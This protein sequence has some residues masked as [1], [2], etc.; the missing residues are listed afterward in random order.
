[1][2]NVFVNDLNSIS[3]QSQLVQFADDAQFLVFGTPANL[4]DIV[5]N[6]E[7]TLNRAIR[8]F[9][10]NG[11]KVNS[12]KTKCIFIGSRA[13]I[14]RI[15]NDTVVKVGSSTIKLSNTVKNL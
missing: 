5:G 3:Q 15:P 7:A 13:Y 12:S 2:F 10:E 4:N 1:M 8:Y 11:L 6:A 9:S 14:D